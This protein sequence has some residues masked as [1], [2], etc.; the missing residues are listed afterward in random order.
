MIKVIIQIPCY[1]EAAVLPGTLRD[2]PRSL[3]GVDVLEWLVIDDGSTD[4][5]SDVART[6]GVHHI[7]RFDRNRGL[8]SAFAAGLEAAIKAGADIVVN[9]DADNQYRA[10][11][12][13][14]LVTPIVERRADIVI[15]DRRVGSLPNFSWLKRRLQVLGSW[16]LGRAAE[17]EV[18][19]A[20]SG[21]RALSRD[22]ALRTLVLSNYSY[23]LETLIQAGAR[24]AAVLFVPVGI[25]PQTRPS[26][27]MRNIPEY[28]GKSTV[29]IVRAYAMYRPL[30][31]FVTL[32]SV[33]ILLGLLPGFR[34]LYFY[35]SGN[36]VGH[37]QSLILAAV[38]LIVGFQIVLIGLVADVLAS[39]RK[40]LEEVVYRL[41]RQD[42]DD[43][44]ESGTTTR[45]A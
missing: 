19:D 35:F 9:T 15:G 25:N 6:L 5:T 37:V 11:D 23:T 1:N 10:D 33:L 30:R 20:T 40:L 32:G 42:A 2:L 36:R 29:T 44:E 12:I 14:A 17:L 27:L 28:I 7:V 41:R 4:T 26:R 13:A 3:P 34:F 22:A 16:V 43:R 45:D 38:L 24:R 39:N 8:A 21:F 18:P 31:V